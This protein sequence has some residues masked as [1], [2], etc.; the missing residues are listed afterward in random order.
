MQFGSGAVVHP[1]IIAITTRAN[2]EIN[3]EKGNMMTTKKKGKLRCGILQKNGESF[4]I[5]LD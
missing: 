1:V 2:K 5:T 3:I 4:I